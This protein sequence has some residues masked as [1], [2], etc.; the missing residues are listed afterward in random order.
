VRKKD[1]PF[2]TNPEERYYRMLYEELSRE[3]KSGLTKEDMAWYLDVL[4]AAARD[5]SGKQRDV[6]HNLLVATLAAREGP[7]GE[8]IQQ[9]FAERDWVFDHY[10]I[11]RSIGTPPTGVIGR[12]RQPRWFRK[13]LRGSQ[14]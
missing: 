14:P 8:A 9:F 1:E 12:M 11:D 2:P 6:R 3:G 4:D 13:H 10:G 7:H 5:L